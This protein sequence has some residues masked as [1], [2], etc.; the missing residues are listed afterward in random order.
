MKQNKGLIG[1]VKPE[2][3][4]NHKHHHDGPYHRHWQANLIFLEVTELSVFQE[5]KRKYHCYVLVWF[6]Q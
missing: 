4:E 3:Q 1:D 2:L 5:K 6:S